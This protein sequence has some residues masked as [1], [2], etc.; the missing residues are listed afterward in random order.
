MT[1]QPA[2]VP[3][4]LDFRTT[5][6]NANAYG[7]WANSDTAWVVNVNS[8]DDSP[9]VR[10]YTYNNIPV[11]VNY[12]AAT[13]SVDETDDTSTTEVNESQVTVTVT[14]SADPK[15][16]VT[17]PITKTEQDGASNSDYSGVPANVVFN[18]SD[19]EKTFSFNATADDDNDDGE[20]VKLGFDTS[21]PAGVTEGSTNEAIVSIT[22]D[23]VLLWRSASSRGRTRWPRGA[24]SQ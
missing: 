12:G 24:A 16:T 4:G 3:R 7:I 6:S 14:L 23:D 9:F 1:S 15:R 20:S 5:S 2:T 18:A 10:I 17:I 11:T 21:L 22:D 13:Y 19:T 8:A